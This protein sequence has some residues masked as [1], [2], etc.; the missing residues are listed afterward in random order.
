MPHSDFRR[1][2]YASGLDNERDSVWENCRGIGYSFG[3]N[4]EEDSSQLLTP[5]ELAKHWIDVV[6]RGGRLLLNVGPTAKGTIPDL[7]R[8]TLEGFGRWKKQVAQDSKTARPLN[9]AQSTDTP[10]VRWWDTES[11][12]IL[13]VASLG[14]FTVQGP[15]G[16]RHQVVV[17]RLDQGP[18]VFRF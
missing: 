11:G 5:V 17:D 13:F 18:A 3:F 16:N 6:S 2:E 14:T 4:A 9:G 1:S 7:Q 15:D 12:P 8:S 10:W